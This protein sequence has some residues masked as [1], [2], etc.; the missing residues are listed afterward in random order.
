MTD[1][2]YIEAK[3]ERKSTPAKPSER[4]HG[5]KRNPRGSASNGQAVTFTPEVTKALRAK[6]AEHNSGGKYR[7]TLAA[8]KAVYRRGAGAFSTSHRPGMTRN[9]WAMGRV[10]A[11]LYLLNHGSPENTKY[12]TDND[13]LP[14]NH[15]RASSERPTAE[16]DDGTHATIF[17][18]ED[19]MDISEATDGRPLI[20]QLPELLANVVTMYHLTHGAHWT[21]KGQ[22]FAQYHELFGEIYEDVF[23]SID[24]IAEFMLKLGYDTPYSMTDLVAIRTLQDPADPADGESSLAQ[25]VL[26]INDFVLV[27]LMAIFDQATAENQQGIA[28]FLAERI[29]MHQKWAWQL[30][31][32]L[33]IQSEDVAEA[34]GVYK[35]DM[36]MRFPASAYA[37]VP[38]PQKP[39]T[40]KMRL[41]EDPSKKVTRASIARAAMALSPSGFRGNQVQLPKGEVAAVRSKVAA[42][43]KSV[44][45]SGEKMPAHLAEG[46][47]LELALA[48]GLSASMRKRHA[49]VVRTLPSGAKEYK[50]P[51][52]D[53]AHARAALSYVHRSD[54][55]AAERAKVI[56][57]A[58]KVLGTPI[59]TGASKMSESVGTLSDVPNEIT[60]NEQDFAEAINPSSDSVLNKNEM[61]VTIITPGLNRSGSRYYPSDAIAEAIN[62][63]MFDGRKMFVNHASAS[64]MRD[65]PERSLTDW[66]STIKETWID[67]QTGAAQARIKIVQNWFGD[68]LKQLQ[69]NDALPDVGLSIFAQGQVQRK[70]VDGR[71]TDVV[72]RFTRALSVDWVTE[73]GAGGRVDAIWESYQPARAKELEI[74]VLNTM[75]VTDAV[76]TLREQRPDIIEVLEADNGRVEELATRVAELEAE[77][78]ERDAK[79]VEAAEQAAKAEQDVLVTE[80]LTAAELPTAAADRVRA[81]IVEP[82]LAE[83]HTLDREAAEAKVNELIEAEKAYAEQIL[84]EA[85]P[86]SA[87][88]GISGLGDRH[89]VAPTTT[90]DK[91]ESDIARRMGIKGAE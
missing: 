87:G 19:S 16:V 89:E 67:P 22:D 12:V 73:P 72:E 81:S 80:A 23:D 71:L 18:I 47:D 86:A 25:M 83:D 21:V 76:T 27:Q 20:Q 32:S 91:V 43:W 1:E 31:A 82:I 26:S 68:F 50:F 51:I 84:S 48:E 53:K 34:D 62:N 35:T 65:R 58:H 56:R 60:S 75:T 88:R 77:I 42:A 55:T 36:G 49:T 30:R 41:W 2:I 7:T 59:G 61:V 9:Q 90:I 11:F 24:T 38:D 15:P 85:R 45:T 54:L 74:N 39:S 6:V 28:N 33:G 66:V 78:A 4:V 64:E 37:Y 17:H 57:K 63:G 13:L 52:P 8:L 29:D 10:N 40:W 46:S 79:L 5:S 69:E 14:L 44:H 70:K 3:G